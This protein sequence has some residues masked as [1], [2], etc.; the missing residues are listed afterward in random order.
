MNTHESD[1]LM[2][3]HEACSLDLRKIYFAETSIEVKHHL[4]LKPGLGPELHALFLANLD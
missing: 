2:H 4:L 3:V 1:Q